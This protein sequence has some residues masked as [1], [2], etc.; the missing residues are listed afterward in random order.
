MLQIPPFALW[1]ENEKLKKAVYT[2]GGSV[3]EDMD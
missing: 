2:Y 3:K 1:H